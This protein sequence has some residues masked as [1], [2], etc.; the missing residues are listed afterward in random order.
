MVISSLS[1]DQQTNEQPSQ[2]TQNSTTWI[3]VS[4]KSHTQIFWY[5]YYGMDYLRTFNKTKRSRLR[6]R[7]LNLTKKKKK[8][9]C[10]W[11][12]QPSCWLQTVGLHH[13]VIA[14]AILF[15][16]YHKK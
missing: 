8:A 9:L 12:V 11:K 10:I 2:Q 14:R 1:R 6:Y 7:S 16:V 5:C 3:F 15:G 4:Y 13:T